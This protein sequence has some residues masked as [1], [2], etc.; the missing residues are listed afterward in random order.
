MRFPDRQAAGQQLG[1]ALQQ[2]V[3]GAAVVYAIP[4][5]GVVVAGE[6]ARALSA[7]L[8]LIV[9]REIADP[10]RP[11]APAGAITESGEQAYDDTECAHLDPTWLASRAK[12]EREQALRDRERLVG[13]HPRVPAN[14]KYAVIVADGIADALA[15]KAALFA[16]RADGPTRLL[17]AAPVASRAVVASLS[18]LCDDV[19]ALVRT[20]PCTQVRDQYENYPAMTDGDVRRELLHAAHPPRAVLPEMIGH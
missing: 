5:C 17:I 7:P 14:G 19:I 16:I 15:I 6:V 13:G 2:H 1:R 11:E 10:L 18:G 3:Y 9:V 8:D 20:D 4:S 12:S